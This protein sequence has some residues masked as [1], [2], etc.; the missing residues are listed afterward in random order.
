MGENFEDMEAGHHGG[1]AGGDPRVAR[2]AAC[3]YVTASLGIAALYVLA[4]YA[5]G[6]TAVGRW[7]G[8]LWV[9]L[10][11][12]IITMPLLTSYAKRRAKS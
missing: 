2:L 6:A 9:L 1:D 5:T 8:A 10:L 12:F 7:G 11:S 4:T 3:Y